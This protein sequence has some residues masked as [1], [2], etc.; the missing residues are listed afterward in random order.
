MSLYTRRRVLT[1]LIGG[2]AGYALS[3]T[4]SALAVS[5]TEHEIALHE[6][7]LAER[8]RAAAL[9]KRET[10]N[11]TAPVSEDPSTKA[12]FKAVAL[13]ADLG[14][15]KWAFYSNILLTGAGG[16]AGLFWPWSPKPVSSPAD[17][18]P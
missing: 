15:K 8:V 18:Q 12:L 7:T 3:K 14:A 17:P 6:R 2:A 5:G 9:A 4:V 11:D 16:L 1:T 10:F 13:G